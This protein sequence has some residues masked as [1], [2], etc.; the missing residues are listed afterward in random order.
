V[1]EISEMN[2]TELINKHV[3][4]VGGIK[5]SFAL[6]NDVMESNIFLTH[7]GQVGGGSGGASGT[8]RANFRQKGGRSNFGRM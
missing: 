3:E 5:S 8:D 7:L 6:K 2:K 1:Q 4:V